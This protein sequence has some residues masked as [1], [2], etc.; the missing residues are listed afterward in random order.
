MSEQ[1]RVPRL[2]T[3]ATRFRRGLALTALSLLTLAAVAWTA[4]L[5]HHFVTYEMPRSHIEVNISYGT[6]RLCTEEYPVFVRVANNSSKKVV[7]YSFSLQA[8]LPGQVADQADRHTYRVRRVITPG[9]G[10]GSC[11]RMKK[12]SDL[13]DE[14]L[15]G[16]NLRITLTDFAPVFE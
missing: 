6:E 8:R 15:A 9:N 1:D 2:S 3:G 14:W 7:A 4:V 16:S 11:W 10:Y 13:A 12:R 5:A